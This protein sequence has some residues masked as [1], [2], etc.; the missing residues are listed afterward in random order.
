MYLLCSMY[1]DLK[2]LCKDVSLHSL[3]HLSLVSIFYFDVNRFELCNLRS[4]CLMP[5]L[6]GETEI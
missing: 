6:E 4:Y 3:F 5:S 1:V 2:L